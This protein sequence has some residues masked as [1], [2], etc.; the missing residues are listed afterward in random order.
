MAT[1]PR[2]TEK[3]SPKM[4]MSP[5]FDTTDD[6]STAYDGAGGDI[7]RKSL[8]SLTQDL[9]YDELHTTSP[10]RQ[11]PSPRQA[12]GA[13]LLSTISNAT[14]GGAGGALARSKS[15]LHSRTKSIAATYVPKPN[16]DSGAS[17]PEKANTPGNRQSAGFFGDFFGGES[18]PVRL[19]VPPSQAESEE[20]CMD[21]TSGF[22][23]R[24]SVFRRPTTRVSAPPKKNAA[25]GKLDGWFGRKSTA[26]STV[27]ANND[28]LVNVN[29][30]KSL[31]PHGQADS[32]DPH[33]FN[34]LLLN[35][36]ELL[37]R[38]QKAYKEK[39]EYIASIQPEIDVQ[40]E[41]VEEA[42]TRACHLKMQ[43]E[44][45]SRKKFE[46]EEAMREMALQLA[47]EKI[48]VQEA[49]DAL[50]SMKKANETDNEDTPR[51]RKRNSDGS[52]NAS[53][54][55]FESDMDYAESV[56][57]NGL[58]AHL[59]H[60]GSSLRPD[61]NRMDSRLSNATDLSRQSSVSG[62]SSLRAAAI[63]RKRLSNDSTRVLKLQEENKNLQRQVEIMQRQ[64]QGCIDF[65]SG[66]AL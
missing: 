28:E 42:E 40:K 1:P 3:L 13:R 57:S 22:T 56:V 35:A 43:L 36:T 26:V 4:F 10:N 16:Q 52:A 49:R 19:G 58:D 59:H 33:A 62:R 38:M 63:E 53:D 15:M 34:D 65:V 7:Q 31:F 25:G 50:Q 29:I 64:L 45:M 20:Y 14:Q 21:Y 66:V 9:G 30:N 24:P 46:Q 51:R 47:E 54:S 48:K 44:D 5:E 27:L 41:E 60:V 39:V 8:N 23:E 2:H 11:L 6:M 32:L 61:C 37:Q 17:S 12:I 18:A 55:G